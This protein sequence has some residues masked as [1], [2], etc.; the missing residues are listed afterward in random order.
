MLN[1][2]KFWDIGYIARN[3]H[4]G[5]AGTIVN[6]KQ[7]TMKD[8]FD[9]YEYSVVLCV[10]DYL[11]GNELYE[12]EIFCKEHFGKLN[13]YDPKCRWQVCS[14]KETD[15]RRPNKSI[16]KLIFLFHNA[17]DAMAFKLRWI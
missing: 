12:I 15:V 2:F 11:T 4:Y 5:D 16:P 3:S 13:E 1:A 7:A 6:G 9:Q 17:D 14:N 8:I 10:T